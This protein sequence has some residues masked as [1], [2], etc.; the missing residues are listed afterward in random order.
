MFG[1]ACL[2]ELLGQEITIPPAIEYVSVV[3]DSNSVFIQWTP[4]STINFKG[5]NIY[6]YD[7]PYISG[8]DTIFFTDSLRNVLFKYDTVTIR[9]VTL[10]MS[11]VKGTLREVLSILNH[12][13]VFLTTA[14]DSCAHTITLTWTKYIGWDVE[15]Y[16]IYVYKPNNSLSLGVNTGSDTTFVIENFEFGQPYSYYVA[17]FQKTNNQP[18]ISNS[19]R[20]DI[21]ISGPLA[22]TITADNA[23]FTSNNK[24]EV[25]FSLTPTPVNNFIYHVTKSVYPDSGFQVFTEKSSVN[26]YQSITISDTAF[27]TTYYRIEWLLKNDCEKGVNLTNNVA[28]AIVPKIENNDKFINLQ[29]DKYL[30]W[31]DNV[32]YN[33]FR[34]GSKIESEISGT[35]IS[36]PISDLMGKNMP[37][38]V[39]Y[40]I[41]AKGVN[42][43]SKSATVCIN[44]EN[45]I[46]I[47]EGFTPNGNDV[48]RVFK[49]WFAFTPISYSL[50]I[51]NRFGFKVFETKNI[52]NGWE[53][54][55]NGKP[56]LDGVYVYFITFK[57]SSGKTVEKSGN[58][59]LIYL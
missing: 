41:E 8:G 19:N 50:V 31:G 54:N 43:V 5:Y 7:S 16:E 59:S 6:E 13:T 3:P 17:A 56:A 52:D 38:E 25:Q 42:S 36:D 26:S 22:P 2:S 15:K 33:I 48:N 29:W 30:G 12:R 40:Y 58:L 57:T 44:V 20:V 35:T 51:F 32:Q 39:C 14:V 47:P 53:G 49:P 46:F 27:A 37:D 34:N 55:Y 10:A 18:F 11:T 24:V 9:A 4:S 1:F 23:N 45:S 28:T 21:N